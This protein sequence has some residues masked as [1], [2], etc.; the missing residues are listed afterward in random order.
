MRL[1]KRL[2]RVRNEARK[3]GS[4]TMRVYAELDR[5]EVKRRKN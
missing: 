1:P 5:L 2:R 3:N 4:L